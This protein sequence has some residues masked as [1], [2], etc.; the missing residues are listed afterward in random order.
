ME[1]EKN[2]DAV[3]VHTL[4]DLNIYIDK[5]GDYKTKLEFDVLC[6]ARI[7]KVLD[8]VKDGHASFDIDLNKNTTLIFHNDNE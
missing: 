3:K 5:K 6:A 2:P 4:D 8:S 7:Q 1:Q